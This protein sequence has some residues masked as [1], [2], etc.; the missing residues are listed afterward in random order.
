[1]DESSSTCC[2]NRKKRALLSNGGRLK[3]AAAL[4]KREIQLVRGEVYALSILTRVRFV[5][6]FLVAETRQQRRQ[7][8][9][10]VLVL[11]GLGFALRLCY[12]R[13]NHG[14]AKLC[15]D[16]G[17]YEKPFVDSCDNDNDQSEYQWVGANSLD[18]LGERNGEAELLG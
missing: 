7:S 6:L 4:F 12:I 14:Y 1:M 3:G 8:V 11:A 13:C 16:G 9:V 15:I 10:G 17:K 2:A 5:L 18:P